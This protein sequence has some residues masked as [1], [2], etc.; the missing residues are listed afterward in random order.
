MEERNVKLQVK[1]EWRK[2]SIT[3]VPM[4]SLA[5]ILLIASILSLPIIAGFISNNAYAI[6]QGET[7]FPQCV[8]CFG[9]FEKPLGSLTPIQSLPI[10]IAMFVAALN[11]ILFHSSGFLSFRP[12]FIKLKAEVVNDK[13]SS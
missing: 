3:I 11:V 2:T 1:S 12:W 5:L 10:E 8:Y 13:N 4:L 9:I 6:N 7:A